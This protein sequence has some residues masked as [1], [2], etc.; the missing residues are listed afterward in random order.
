MDWLNIVLGIT[1]F[2]VG[3]LAAYFKTK[4]SITAMVSY[5]ISQTENTTLTGSEK[6]TEVV[7]QLYDKVPA[8]LKTVFTKNT[9]EKIAQKIFDYMKEYAVS[10]AEKQ[11]S[12][13]DI[14]DTVAG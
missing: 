1:V 6:M 14:V 3:G 5:L 11:D 7:A 9:L 4:S 12:K 13:G 10:W 8:A 2:V